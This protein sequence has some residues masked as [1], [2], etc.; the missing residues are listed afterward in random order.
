MFVVDATAPERFPE[1]KEELHRLHEELCER[2][3]THPLL[4]VAN[5]MDSGIDAERLA[6]ISLALDIG[7]LE[8][9]RAMAIKV[10]PKAPEISLG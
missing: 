2:K 6:E 7:G 10:Q 4:V 8:K 5:K 3:Y 1:A 9:G